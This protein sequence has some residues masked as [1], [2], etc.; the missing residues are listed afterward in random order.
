MCTMSFTDS[1]ALIAYLKSV[2]VKH[3]VMMVTHDDAHF[4]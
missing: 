1:V 3:I 4:S 2:N